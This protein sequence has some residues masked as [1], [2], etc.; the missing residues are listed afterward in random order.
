MPRRQ[1]AKL[2]GNVYAT[3]SW[4][5]DENNAEETKN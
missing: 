4:W 5:N 1:V 2:G 3:A